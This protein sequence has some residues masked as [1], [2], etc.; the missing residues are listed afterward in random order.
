MNTIPVLDHGFVRIHNIAGPTRRATTLDMFDAEDTDPA[1]CA[2][3]SF[4]QMDSNRTR[5]E[6][7]RLAEYLMKNKHTSPFE[8][9]VVW[10]EMKLPIFVARQWV[11]HR[12]ASLNEV[13]GRYVKLPAEWY[14][15]AIE[16]VELQTPSKKQGGK[17]IDLGNPHEIAIAEAYRTRLNH[18]CAQ[19]YRSYLSSIEDGI[20]MEHA[21]LDLHL[22][23]YTHWLWKQ[24]LHNMMHLLSLREDSHAQFEIRQYAHAIANALRAQLPHSM[25]LYDKYRKL[26]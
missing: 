13:S 20:A 14:I 8:M 15:P 19:A 5:E 21:R 17:F 2:R 26:S 6:D 23:H 9:I 16:H 10:V 25:E 24:D 18:N 3:M 7:L 12:T 4:D 1:N 22:N 11:R